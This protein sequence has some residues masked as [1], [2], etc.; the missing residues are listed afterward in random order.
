M[1][2]FEDDTEYSMILVMGV[3]GSG[4]SFFVNKLA[5]QTVSEGPG[6]RSGTIEPN[7]YL[8]MNNF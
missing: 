3:T 7:A 1:P 6:L 4:K 5:E 8:T 2:A